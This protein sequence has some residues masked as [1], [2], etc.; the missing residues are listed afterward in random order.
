MFKFA[1]ICAV[2]ANICAVIFHMLQ[3]FNKRERFANVGDFYSTSVDLK[4][5][6]VVFYSIAWFIGGGEEYF[7]NADSFQV[8]VL[9]CKVFA[10]VWITLFFLG[11]LMIIAN[12]NNN[13]NAS[14][15]RRANNSCLLIAMIYGLCSFFLG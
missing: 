8:V 12:R 15:I 4:V 3:I 2:A 10:I 13:K 1:V 7:G 5:I 6:G 11:V 14:S 9:H